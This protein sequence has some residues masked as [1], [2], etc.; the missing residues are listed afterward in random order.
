VKIQHYSNIQPTKFDT[1]AVK[2]I[3]G[4]VAIGKADGAKNFCMRVFE[5]E[6]TA[7]L[8][9]TSMT[10]NM[11]FFSTRA[12]VKYIKMAGGFLLLQAARPLYRATRSTR[13]AIPATGR[14]FLSA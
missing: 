1:P 11:K 5:V 6:K 8:P 10:G 7:I 4:R 2:G 9:G 12:A 13:Y 14:L 3:S